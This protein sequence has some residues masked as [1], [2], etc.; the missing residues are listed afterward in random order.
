MHTY[1]RREPRSIPAGQFLVHNHIQRP[2]RDQV[3]VNGWR[4]WVQDADPSNAPLVPC[5]CGWA[6]RLGTHHKVKRTMEAQ[7]V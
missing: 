1:L 7:E 2:P 6:A 4:I 3:G 5:D